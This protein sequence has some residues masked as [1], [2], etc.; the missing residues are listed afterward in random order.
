M[1]FFMSLPLDS[2]RKSIMFLGCPIV[3]FVLLFV[4]PFI[5]LVIVTKMSYQHL[6]QFW[7]IWQG[8]F[9]I[10]YGICYPMKLIL[11]QLKV[12][13]ALLNA[14]LLMILLANSY[15]QRNMFYALFALC[16]LA[17]FTVTVSIG[18]LSVHVC[19]LLSCSVVICQ[20]IILMCYSNE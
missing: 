14:F 3:P 16:Q 12:L 2:I 15:F 10:P 13:H 9:T 1:M 17:W 18:Q 7:W 4:Y 6:G 8:I 11:V 5:W 19:A 20:T